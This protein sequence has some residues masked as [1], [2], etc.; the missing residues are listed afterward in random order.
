M[1]A[2]LDNLSSA[3]KVVQDETRQQIGGIDPNTASGVLASL[4]E[5]YT[6]TLAKLGSRDR[7][8]L[9]RLVLWLLATVLAVLLLLGAVAIRRDGGQK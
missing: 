2:L 8:D 3:L 4:L 1:H 6:R 9:G 5:G 7:P